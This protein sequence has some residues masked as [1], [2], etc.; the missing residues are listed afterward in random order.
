MTFKSNLHSLTLVLLASAST[1]A[2]AQG[3]HLAGGAAVGATGAQTAISGNAQTGASMLKG[4]V[5]DVGDATHGAANAA[6]TGTSATADSAQA[7][8]QGGVTA[9]S[10]ELKGVNANGMAAGKTT[11]AAG[12]S[13]KADGNGA[14]HR[15]QKKARKS[16]AR[17]TPTSGEANAELSTSTNVSVSGGASAKTGQ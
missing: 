10:K 7:E 3:V 12:E 8:A 17:A 9:A 13:A 6:V 4:T 14:A 11:L 5:Q 2:L 15:S 1:L 16:P